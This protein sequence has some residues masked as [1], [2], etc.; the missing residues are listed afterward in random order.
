MKNRLE[1]DRLDME[2]AKLAQDIA[3]I[4]RTPYDFTQ[5]ELSVARLAADQTVAD[6]DAKYRQHRAILMQSA[7]IDPWLIASVRKLD[8]LQDEL[9]W[10]ADR[11]IAQIRAARSRAQLRAAQA[12]YE[13][14]VQQQILAEVAWL[15][16]ELDRA[17]ATD[18][19]PSKD[20]QMP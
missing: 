16:A 17:K 6:L 1:N 5:Y 20:V 8:K 15:N 7:R 10:T 14:S 2:N 13:A 12:N 19:P 9:D 4:E 3:R 11:C 18:R